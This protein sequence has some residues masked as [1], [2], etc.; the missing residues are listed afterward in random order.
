MKPLDFSGT[1]VLGGEGAVP[2]VAA[3]GQRSAAFSRPLY[4]QTNF[5]FFS[6]SARQTCLHARVN[7]MFHRFTT[8]HTRV[9]RCP[10][11]TA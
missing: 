6:Q 7:V 2:G 4:I 3:R 11:T 9:D 8:G 5:T 10:N 1:G